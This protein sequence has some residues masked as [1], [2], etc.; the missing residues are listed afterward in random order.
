VARLFDD[1]SSEYLQIDST[2][3]T[4]PPFTLACRAYLD[5][6]TNCYAM[7]VGDK[8][9]GDEWY[10]IGYSTAANDFYAISRNTAVGYASGTVGV[11]TG[12]WYHVT[13]VFAAT[14]SRTIYT[15]GADKQTGTTAVTVSGADRIAI[16]RCADVSP[17]LYWSGMIAEAAIWS[18]AL[19]D[20]EV[21]ALAAGLRPTHI[22]PASLECY[23]PL[24]RT[25]QD[26]V[27]G[28]DMTAYNTPSWAD[29]P[30]KI[31]YSF[32]PHLGVTAAAAPVAGQPMML[33]GTTVPHMARQWHPRVA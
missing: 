26:L 13:A 10:G 15:N 25:D 16:G 30:P 24:L 1:G 28:Y 33:R 32:P 20:A 19:S 8:D 9:A 23:W 3:V 17:L 2:P 18:A 12:T 21:A 7:W 6:D 22:R 29:H 14:N 5:A 27:G 4:A 31:F 11:S